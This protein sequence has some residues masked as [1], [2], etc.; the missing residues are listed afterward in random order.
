MNAQPYKD[1]EDKG[2]GSVGFHAPEYGAD[3]EKVEPEAV[4]PD[5]NWLIRPRTIK[6]L[7]WVFAIILAM[8]V[9]AQIFISIHDYFT[10]DGW[11]AFYAI[12]GFV[13][14]L[15][16]SLLELIEGGI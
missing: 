14:C 6:L 4:A 9:F 16:L 3:C 12:F 1:D 11:F 5:S 15:A 13:S 8:T 10:V 7:W 2:L